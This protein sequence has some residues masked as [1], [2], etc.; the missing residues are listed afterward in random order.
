MLAGMAKPFLQKVLAPYGTL[1]ALS[2]DSVQRRVVLVVDLSGETE[3]TEVAVEN[4][5]IQ[6]EGAQVWIETPAEAFTSSRVWLAA[7]LNN[8][9]AGKR[10]EIPAAYA[11]Y[12]E[13]LL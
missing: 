8:V 10:I 9:V 6:R 13:M 7:L 11:R 12:A 5:R 3:P 4:Y 1:R 2:M